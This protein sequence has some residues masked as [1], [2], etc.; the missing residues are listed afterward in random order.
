M[1]PNYDLSGAHQCHIEYECQ[2]GLVKSACSNPKSLESAI[3]KYQ[4]EN[5]R[6]LRLYAKYNRVVQRRLSK[7]ASESLSD[8]LESKTTKNYD[9]QSC[10]LPNAVR[11]ILFGTDNMLSRLSEEDAGLR[12][13][14]E[15]QSVRNDIETNGVCL[16]A[17]LCLAKQLASCDDTLGE[18]FS[19]FWDDQQRDSTMPFDR[20]IRL[21]YC[22][23]ATWYQIIG[24]QN[25]LSVV[26]LMSLKQAGHLVRFAESQPLPFSKKTLISSGGCGEVSE[27]ELIGG[28]Q[29]LYRVVWV[30]T[31][32]S[33]SK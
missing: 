6:N 22:N 25:R 13:M 9:N 28:H 19:G 1:A 27:I 33:S 7:T 15:D 14:I 10:V 30:C 11:S 32:F 4:R 26:E 17:T 24:I 8:L 31:S 3:A 12:N 20:E 18:L 29:E 16:L 23:E 2:T 5:G 21:C